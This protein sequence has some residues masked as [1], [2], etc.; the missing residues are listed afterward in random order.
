MN[1]MKNVNLIQMFEFVEITNKI[2]NHFSA[3]F[4]RV[5]KIDFQIP[6]F[7]YFVKFKPKMIRNISQIISNNNNNA[8]KITKI[9]Y[10]CEG[11]KKAGYQKEIDWHENIMP[12]CKNCGKIQCNMH[13]NKNKDLC[14]SCAGLNNICIKSKGN[15]RYSRM[16]YYCSKIICDCYWKLL[17]KKYNDNGIYAYIICDEHYEECKMDPNVQIRGNDK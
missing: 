14:M 5:K 12:I 1:I 8:P 2:V 16:C 6:F 3:H 4:G 10:Y 9:Y 7:F 15:C 17:I 11:H 13:I